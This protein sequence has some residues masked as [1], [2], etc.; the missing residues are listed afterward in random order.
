[1]TEI[2]IGILVILLLSINGLQNYTISKQ[3][4]QIDQH[5]DTLVEYMTNMTKFVQVQNDA[6]EAVINTL[7]K[8]EELDAETYKAIMALAHHVQFLDTTMQNIRSEIQEMKGG[9]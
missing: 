3:Q 7:A 2:I 1:M 5:R 4:D 9:E 8:D 6:N